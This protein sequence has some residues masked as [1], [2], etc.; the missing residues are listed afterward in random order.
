MTNYKLRKGTQEEYAADI[1]QYHYKR[2][3]LRG[4]RKIEYAKEGRLEILT[5]YGIDEKT[6]TVNCIE[7]I[8]TLTNYN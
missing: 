2:T 1:K 3:V 7:Y 4:Q 5:K 8:K 6:F